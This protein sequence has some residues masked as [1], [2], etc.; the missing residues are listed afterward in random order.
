[1]TGV[2]YAAVC[3]GVFEFL[4]ILCAATVLTSSG[5]GAPEGIGAA[6]GGVADLVVLLLSVAAAIV[7]Y[8]LQTARVPDALADCF[9]G[10]WPSPH[11]GAFADAS[12]SDGD[13]TDWRI[14]T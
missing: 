14:W 8:G 7:A 9:P 3:S 6:I 13:T 2:L 11:P 5:I 12:L 1:M 4:G 10:G